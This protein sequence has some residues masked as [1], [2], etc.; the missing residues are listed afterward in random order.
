[1]AD[2]LEV[3]LPIQYH[4]C[5]VADGGGPPVNLSS[6]SLESLMQQAY[7]EI[8][9]AGS[10]W[11]HFIIDGQRCLISSPSQIFQLRTP[12]GMLLPMVDPG[13]AVFD[14]NGKFSILRPRLDDLAALFSPT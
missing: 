9:K 10:G 5:L 14:P 12:H 13:A 1:V 6:D 2:T 8:V 4:F 11:C 3:K 7:Q